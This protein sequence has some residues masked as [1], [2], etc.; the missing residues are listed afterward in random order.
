M[1]S[2]KAENFEMDLQLGRRVLPNWIY[3]Y[4]AK[5]KNQ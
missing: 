3:L 2:F 4:V 1:E 5:V